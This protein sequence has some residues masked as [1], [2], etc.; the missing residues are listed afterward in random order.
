MMG[1][2]RLFTEYLARAAALALAGLIGGCGGGDDDS[3]ASIT[4]PFAVDAAWRNMLAGDTDFSLSGIGSDSASYTLL[5]AL[6]PA[7]AGA[8]PLT[9]EVGARAVQ[10]TQ[11]VQNGVAFAPTTTVQF[12]EPASAELIGVSSDAGECATVTSNGLLPVSAGVGSGGPLYT[13]TNYDRC[14]GA[15]LPIGSV[16]ADWSIET[17]AGIVF[18]CSTAALFDAAGNDAG[19]ESDCIQIDIDGT[20]GPLARTTVVVPPRQG[21]PSG[22]TLVARNY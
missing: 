4:D 13:A 14:D 20:L 9:G 18:F 3:G 1:M 5:V 21:A 15:A 11:L 22:F 7:A 6:R 12:Y 10:T 2:R 8:Y 17:E 16:V 19:S